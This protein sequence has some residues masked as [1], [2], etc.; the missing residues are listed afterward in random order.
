MVVNACKMNVHCIKLQFA[1]TFGLFTAKCCA[2]CC[3]THCILVLNASHFGAKRKPFWC[4]TQAILVQNTRHFGAKRKAKRCKMQGKTH[5]NTHQSD[6]QN[7]FEPLKTGLK[8]GKTYIKK[9]GF[10]G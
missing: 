3:K 6:R 2:I 5:K 8:S 9:W 7:P 4:K 1:P 10:S